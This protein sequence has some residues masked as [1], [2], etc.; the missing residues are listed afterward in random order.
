MQIGLMPAIVN[1]LCAVWDIPPEPLY[2]W[3][4]VEMN[5]QPLLVTFKAG[6]QLHQGFYAKS[7]LV[8]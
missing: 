6:G 8:P 1:A 4:Q 2:A 5:R 7:G 3:S